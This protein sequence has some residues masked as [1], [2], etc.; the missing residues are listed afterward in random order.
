MAGVT[1]DTFRA[2]AHQG[3]IPDG[4]VYR[5]TPRGNLRVNRE[6]LLEWLDAAQ[7]KPIWDGDQARLFHR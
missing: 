1:P 2:W 4:I 6:K 5:L 3:L 7:K